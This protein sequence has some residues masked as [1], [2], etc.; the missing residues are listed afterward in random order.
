MGITGTRPYKSIAGINVHQIS[1]VSDYEFAYVSDD[2][3]F[4]INTYRGT[5]LNIPMGYGVNEQKVAEFTVS[6]REFIIRNIDGI[7]RV[8]EVLYGTQKIKYGDIS[9]NVIKV[10]YGQMYKHGAGKY[11]L[12]DSQNQE[13]KAIPLFENGAIDIIAKNTY[14]FPDGNEANIIKKLGGYNLTSNNELFYNGTKVIGSFYDIGLFK[15]DAVVGLTIGK[16]GEAYESVRGATHLFFNIG[17]VFSS[18]HSAY[19]NFISNANKPTCEWVGVAENQSTTSS[20]NILCTSKLPTINGTN[21]QKYVA[22]GTDGVTTHFYQLNGS[23][24]IKLE[25][26]EKDA[27]G[28]KALYEIPQGDNLILFRERYGFGLEESENGYVS[29]N[30]FTY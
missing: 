1:T 5:S 16:L 22:I 14:K 27:N 15:Q 12:T 7:A 6:G 30:I 17:N 19:D 24:A 25:A 21:K 2:G 20:P 28:F 4:L 13:L 11:V 18:F 10:A 3:L 26:Y 8:A 29:K 9:Q 23:Q